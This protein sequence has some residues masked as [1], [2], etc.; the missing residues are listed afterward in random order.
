MQGIQI[1][2][3][4]PL[5]VVPKA[6]LSPILMTSLITDGH[7]WLF[8]YKS[9]RN[10]FLR[11]HCSYVLNKLRFVCELTFVGPSEYRNTI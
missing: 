9:M 10:K 1:S 2:D 8:A 11:S 4:F 7:L 5:D 6:E 3:V